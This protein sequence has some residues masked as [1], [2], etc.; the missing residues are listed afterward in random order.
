MDTAT[1]VRLRSGGGSAAPRRQANKVRRGKPA[2]AGM[3]LV[4][5]HSGTGDSDSCTEQ[6]GGESNGGQVVEGCP[7]LELSVE[8]ADQ[9]FVFVHGTKDGIS[10]LSSGSCAN[11]SENGSD[12]SGEAQLS[13][14]PRRVFPAR[15]G[16]PSMPLLSA[17]RNSRNSSMNSCGPCPMPVNILPVWAPTLTA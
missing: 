7:L 3:E 2:I 5:R 17:G 11:N 15:T 9:V 6:P 10:R 8:Q 12:Y 16:P 13:S 1:Y 4:R 14:S